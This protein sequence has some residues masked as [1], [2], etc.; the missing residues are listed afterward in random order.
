[1]GVSNPESSPTH[2][3]FHLGSRISLVVIVERHP[4]Q[5]AVVHTVTPVF[6]GEA[7][8]WREMDRKWDTPFDMSCPSLLLEN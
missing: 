4:E 7:V 2:L 8:Q 6:I 1:M 3:F 5:E